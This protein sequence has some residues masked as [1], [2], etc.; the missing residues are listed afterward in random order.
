MSNNEKKQGIM[1]VTIGVIVCLILMLASIPLIEQEFQTMERK[2]QSIGFYPFMLVVGYP[3]LM[4]ILGNCMTKLT[5]LLTGGKKVWC[6][7]YK[8]IHYIIDAICLIYFLLMLLYV[9]MFLPG[10]SGTHMVRI[11]YEIQMAVYQ[12]L[13]S[14]Q[15]GYVIFLIIGWIWYLTKGKNRL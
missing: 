1:S 10:L 8:V 14:Y 6:P 7:R 5:I 2:Y 9:L 12:F 3:L 4:I 15:F 13:E 11:I